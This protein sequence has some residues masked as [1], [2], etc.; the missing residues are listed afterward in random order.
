MFDEERAHGVN[1][2][3]RLR[4]ALDDGTFASLTYGLRKTDQSARYAHRGSILASVVVCSVARSPV[5]DWRFKGYTAT[6]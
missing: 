5:A 4:L 2:A 3:A 1:L 6:H